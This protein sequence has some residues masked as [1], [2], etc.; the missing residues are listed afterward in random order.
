MA[1]RLGGDRV[2]KGSATTASSFNREQLMTKP[3]RY[4]CTVTMQ[5]ELHDRVRE[6][7]KQEDKPLTVWVREL[8]K[9]ELSD[10]AKE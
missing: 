9:R 7:C 2:T 1:P 3:K 5:Q 6:R 4:H 10:P 8:I